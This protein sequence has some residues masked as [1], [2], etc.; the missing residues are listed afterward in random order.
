MPTP[1]FYELTDASGDR[2]IYDPAGPTLCYGPPHTPQCFSGT[3]VSILPSPLGS[4][5]TVTLASFP[6]LF[7][8]TLTLVVPNVNYGSTPKEPISTTAIFTIDRTGF[9][10]P[11]VGQ[12]QFN[13]VDDH[14]QGYVFFG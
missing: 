12:V 14:L 1:I 3:Q 13:T 2:F 5:V 7:T 11:L 9:P 8:S 6:P 10:I 4:L